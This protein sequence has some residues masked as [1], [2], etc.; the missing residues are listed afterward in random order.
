MESCVG[1]ERRTHRTSS[2]GHPNPEPADVADVIFLAPEDGEDAT[3]WQV[4][5]LVRA[6]AS[7]ALAQGIDLR[8]I[9]ELLGHTSMTTTS[10]IYAHLQPDATRVATTQIGALLAQS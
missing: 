10:D 9:Q 8:T 7:F 5:K 1:N 6:A 2:L 4:D 3:G